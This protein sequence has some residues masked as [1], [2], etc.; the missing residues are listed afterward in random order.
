LKNRGGLASYTNEDRFAS[1]LN[2]FLKG[3]KYWVIFVPRET[4]QNPIS[5]FFLFEGSLSFLTSG[6]Y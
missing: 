4:K 3:D 6:Q 1:K 5:D 2:N